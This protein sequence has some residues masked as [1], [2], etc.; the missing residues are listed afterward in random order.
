MLR[1]VAALVL[2]RVAVFEFGVICEVFGIDRARDGVPNFD[3]RVCG[4]EPGVPFADH[5]RSVIDPRSRT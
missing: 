3:F 5:R 1:S 2:D 4:V